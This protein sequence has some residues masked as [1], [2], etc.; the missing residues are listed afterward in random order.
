MGYPLTCYR[1]GGDL[2]TV[3][4]TDIFSLLPSSL[5]VA[6]HILK[7]KGPNRHDNL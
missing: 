2:K 1:F 7:D 6:Y 4:A 3:Y 5:T